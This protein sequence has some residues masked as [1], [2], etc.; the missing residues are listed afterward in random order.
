VRCS[1]VVFEAILSW[2]FASGNG[3]I[4]GWFLLGNSLLRSYG[5]FTGMGGAE[6]LV[7]RCVIT[8]AGIESLDCH[9]SVAWQRAFRRSEN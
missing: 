3:F 1:G 7:C 4:R 2:G 9:V 6:I 8:E 5:V